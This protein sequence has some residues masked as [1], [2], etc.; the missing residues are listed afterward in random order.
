MKHRCYIVAMNVLC[1]LLLSVAVLAQ[2][3]TGTVPAHS[4]PSEANR[5]LRSQDKR[6]FVQNKG[7]WNSQAQFL[8][9]LNN[10]RAWITNNGIVYDYYT[11]DCPT[12]SEP[13]RDKET[14]QQRIERLHNTNIKGHVVSMNFVSSSASTYVHGD[15]Q[16]AAQFNY[17]LGSDASKWASNVPLYG[18]VVQNNV[19]DGIDVR[20]YYD[21]NNIR[22]DFHV[23]AGANPKNI[24]LSFSGQNKLELGNDG[25]LLIGTTMG[26]I[27]HH[28]LFAYQII[29]GVKKQVSCAFV[30]RQDG[31]VV[32]ELGDYDK[33]LELIIDPLIYSTYL[34]GTNGADTAEGLAVDG[35][36]NAYVVSFT[37][38]TN[39]PMTVGNYDNTA[40]GLSDVVVSKFSATGSLTYSTY[41]GGNNFDFARAI[42]VDGNGNAFVTGSTMSPNYPVTAGCYDNSFNAGFG[43]GADAF[44]TKLNSSGNALS[45]ST[46]LGG[47]G[48]EEG[49]GIVVNAN[50]EAYVGG[51]ELKF[52]AGRHPITAGAYNVGVDNTDG[53]E[54]I[55]VTKFNNAGTG[56]IYSAL[57]G[58]T[59]TTDSFGGISLDN[60][61]NAVVLGNTNGKN[62]PVTGGVYQSSNNGGQDLFVTKLNANGTG[63]LLSTFVGGLRNEFATG[64]IAVDGSNDIYIVGTTSLDTT[65]TLNY[66]TTA[67][68]YRTTINRPSGDNALYNDIVVTKLNSTASSLLYSTF[69]GTDSVEQ[70]HGMCIDGSGNVTVLGVTRDGN[71][72]VTATALQ[73]AP[74]GFG[75]TAA[76]EHVV[77]VL[78]TSGTALLYSTYLGG[79]GQES[80]PGGIWRDA[81]GTI[82]FA[83]NSSSTNYP[84]TPGSLAPLQ[85]GGGAD[86]VLVR[87]STVPAPIYVDKDWANQSN[88]NADLGAGVAIFGTT[89]FNT[90]TGGVN[91]AQNGDTVYVRTG[92]SPYNAENVNIN[93]SIK[94]ANHGA[95]SPSTTACTFSL[96]NN[97]VL[98]AGSG[99]VTAAT[100]N[101]NIGSKIADGL[102][103]VSPSGTV[104]LQAGTYTEQIIIDNKSNISIT[105]PALVGGNPQTTIS[106]SVSGAVVQST[107][108]GINTLQNLTITMNTASSQTFGL[109][110]SG[111]SS[112]VHLF[113]VKWIRNG[114]VI[115]G[116]NNGGLATANIPANINDGSD[117]GFGPGIFVFDNTPLGDCPSATL[118][119]N[120]I[121]CSGSPTNLT[122]TQ[123]AGVTPYSII[124]SD[125]ANNT[126]IS[127]I[128]TS[129]FTFSVSPTANTTYT[130]QSIADANCTSGNVSGSAVITILTAF[131][132]TANPSTICTPANITVALSNSQ[133]NV[134]Y[135]LRDNGNDILAA[136]NGNGQSLTWTVS[137]PTAGSHIYTVK[138]TVINNTSCTLIMNGSPTVQVNS[139]PTFTACPTNPTVNI[140]PNSC[141]NVV[142]YSTAIGVSGTPTPTISYIFSGATSGIGNGTGS[143]STFNKG[144]TNVTVRA[145]NSCTS[146]VCS[147]TV[148]VVDNQ[149]P[150]ISCPTNI[151]T[152]VTTNNCGAVVNYPLPT[153]SDNCPIGAS[154]VYTGAMQTYTVPAGVTSIRI[155]AYGAQGGTGANGAGSGVSTG[156]TGGFG[157]SAS[158][159]LSVTP[160]EVLNIFVGGQGGT[161]TAG[162][163]GGGTGGSQNAGG[164]GGATDVRQGGSA[165]VNRVIVA[166]GGGGGG[167][168]GCDVNG[169]NG[170]NGGSGDA[171]GFL[172]SNSPSGG[173]GFP[174]QGAIGGARGIGCAGFLGVNGQNAIAEVGGNGGNGQTCCCFNGNSIPGGGGGGG[175]FIGGGGGGGG[176]AGTTGCS[177]NEKGG[178]GG[179][180]GGSSYTGTLTSA[181][182]TSGVQVGNGFVMITPIPPVVTQTNGLASGATFPIGTTTNTFSITDNAGLTTTCSFTVTVQAPEINVQ[183][184]SNNIVD[185]S[186]TTSAT[187]NT[188]MGTASICGGSINKS[189][190]IQNTGNGT[191]NFISNA[192]DFV[193]ITGSDA[194]QFSVVTQP[195]A[196]I[197]AGGNANFTVAFTPTSAGVKNA[198]I[199]IATNDCDET[200]YDFAIT[201]TGSNVFTF[202]GTGN[203]SDVARWSPSYPGTSLPSACSIV[204]AGQATIPSTVTVTTGGA[205]TINNGASLS[206]ASGSS[207]LIPLAAGAFQ[208]NGTLNISG[209]FTVNKEI[210]SPGIINVNAG[211]IVKGTGAITTSTLTIPAAAFIAPGTSP[212]CLTITGNTTISGTMQ[213]E[214]AGATVCTQYDRLIVSGLATISSGST[215][216]LSNYT[217]TPGVSNSYTIITANALTGTFT[218]V[219]YPS[220]PGYC[221]TLTYT[222]SSLTFNVS[223][224]PNPSFSAFPTPVCIGGGSPDYTY[225]YTVNP[226]AVGGNFSY[227]WTIPTNATVT[228]GSATSASV[229]LRFTSGTTANLSCAVTRNDIAPGCAKTISQQ[230]QI[231]ALPQNFSPNFVPSAACRN[232]GT[233]AIQIPNSQVGVS[234]T[235][236]NASNLNTVVG[237]ATVNGNGLTVPILMNTTNTNLLTGANVI[238]IIAQN[239]LTGCE[240]R[241]NAG[242]IVINENPNPTFTAVP[243]P[244]CSGGGNPS[245]SYTYSVSPGSIGSSFSYQWLLPTNATV[246][247]GSVNSNTVTLRWAGNGANTLSCV[248]T[249]N[250]VSPA[251]ATT[252]STTVNVNQSPLGPISGSTTTCPNVP[253]TYSVPNDPNVLYTWNITPGNNFMGQ[254]T[255][256]IQVTWTSTGT[257]TISCVMENSITG[258]DNTVTLGVTVNTVPAPS[259]SG[260][261]SVCTGT[262]HNYTVTNNAGSTYQWSASGGTISGSGNSISVLW[263]QAGAQTVTVTET[264]NNGCSTSASKSVNVYL[265]PAPSISGAGT[266]CAGETKTY[267]T[268]IVSGMTNQW[269]VS[270]NGQIL[271]NNGSNID[272]KWNGVSA[273][274]T[275]TLTQIN[276]NNTSCSTTVVYTV[277]VGSVPT[278]SFTA[279]PT[280]T[281]VGQ[282]AVYSISPISGAT[283]VW[284][285]IGGTVI[286]AA[287]SNSITVQWNTVSNTNLVGVVATVGACSGGTSV[288]VIT[289]SVPN[290]V[291]TGDNAAC[292]GQTKA[293]I[294]A[295]P[296]TQ[297]TYL[298]AATN[299]ATFPNGNNSA[300]TNILFNNQGLTN[301]TVT[302]TNQNCSTTTV[303]YPVVVSITPNP[304]LSSTSGGLNTA[305]VCALSTHNYSVSFVSG[306]TYNWTVNGGTITAGAG[307]N[308]ITV[309]WGTPGQGSIALVQANGSCSTSVQTPITINPLPSPAINGTAVGCVNQTLSYSTAFT[310]GRSYSWVV[311]INGQPQSFSAGTNAATINVPWSAAGAGVVTVT[312][313]ITATG[314]SKTSNPYNVI[315]NALPTPSISGANAA[316][317]G[318]Q[319]TYSTT[320][321]V[322]SQYVWTVLPTGTNFTG[323]GSN[324]ITV[325][326][327]SNNGSVQV[328]ETNAA[329][330]TATS[331]AVNVT[332]NALPAP[333]FTLAQVAC[334]NQQ[335][336]L[337]VTTPNGTS[338]YAWTVPGASIISGST[339]ST[340]LTVL[341]NSAGS[342]TIGLSETTSAGCSASITKSILINTLPIPV[343]NGA[344]SACAGDIK[345]YNVA[346]P[347]TSSTYSWA[348][349]NGS[350]QGA[351]TGTSISVLWATAGASTVTVTETTT[352]G[353]IGSSQPYAVT[354]NAKPTPVISSSTSGLATGGVCLNSIHSYST[355]NN[356]SAQYLW[357]VTGG[358]IL[359][360]QNSASIQVQWTGTGGTIKVREISIAQCT[361][362]TSTTIII[363]NPPA[364]PAISGDRQACVGQSKTY[365]VAFQTG[366]SYS[367]NLTLNGNPVSFSQTTQGN[368][369][370]LTWGAAGNAV[371]NLTATLN[372]CSVNAA[373][374]QVTVNA[375][376]TPLIS[377]DASACAG[378]SK[379]YSTAFVAGNNYQWTVTPTAS[380]SGQG[381][382]S[383]IVAWNAANS[384]TVSVTET[385][386]AGCPASNSKTV[387]VNAKPQPVP[388]GPAQACTGQILN[389]TATAVLSGSQFVWSVDGTN[390][391]TSSSSPSASF[392]ITTAGQHTV[393]IT[394]TSTQGCIGF[395]EVLV[396]VALTPAPAINGSTSVC[397]GSVINY[398][399]LQPM[400]NSSFTWNVLNGTIQGSAAGS[401]ISVL[402][403]NAGSGT[404]QVTETNTGCSGTSN[405]INVTVKPLPT[406]AISSNSGGLATF[407]VCEGSTHNYSTPVVSGGSY[408]WTV[409]NGTITTGQSSNAITVQWNENV[410]SGSIKVRV[411]AQQCT[412]ETAAIPV[413]INQKPEPAFSYDVN[414]CE[415]VSKTYATTF[416]SGNQYVWTVK[417]N[418]SAFAFTNGANAATINVQWTTPGSGEVSVSETVPSTGCSANSAVAMI[419]VNP[420]PNPVV[421]PSATQLCAG[422]SATF[423][424]VNVNGHT[425][426][427]TVSPTN[428][429]VQ[430][431]G[432]NSITVTFPTAGTGTV[433]VLQTNGQTGC[434]KLSQIVNVTI[435]AV[436]NPVI[437]GPASACANSNQTFA[438]QQPGTNSSFIWSVTGG[439]IAS[440]AGTSSISVLWGGSGTGTVT[441]TEVIGICSTTVS[442]TVT[443]NPLPAPVVSGPSPVCVGSTNTY[444]VVNANNSSTFTWSFVGG[445]PL[446]GTTGSSFS[447]Q[448]AQTVQTA[449]VQ[450]NETN[451]FGC[452][453]SSSQFAVTLVAYPTPAITS[454]TGGIPKAC[455]GS[456]HSY[457]T[458]LVAG[459]SYAWTINAPT[460][461]TISINNNTVTLGYTNAGTATIS[462]KE[463]NPTGC[464]TL[465]TTQVA[466]NPLPNPQISGVQAICLNRTATFGTTNNSG[467]TYLWTATGGGVIQGANN[468]PTV[469]VLF[470]SVSPCTLLVTETT[471]NGCSKQ[472]SAF[473][474]TVNPLP[475]P[476]ISSPSGGLPAVCAL[477]THSYTTPNVSGNSYAWNVVGGTIS[478]GQGTNTI[479][480][481]W[482]NGTGG[483][484]SVTETVNATQCTTATTS[485]VVINPLPAPQVVGKTL[486]CT[487]TPIRYSVFFVAGHSYNW[488]VSPNGTIT[489][490]T[491]PSEIFVTWNTTGN[492]TVSVLQTNS[493][494]GCS[495][496]SQIGVQV[497]A[498]PAPSISGPTTVCAS[499]NANYSVSNTAGNTYTWTVSGGTIINGQGSASIQVAWGAAGSY[500]LSVVE[501][502]TQLECEGSNSLNVLVNPA[503]APVVTGLSLA[504]AGQTN[505]YTTPLVTGDSYNWTVTGGSIESGQGT[506]QIVVRWAATATLGSVMVTESNGLCSKQSSQIAVQIFQLA[507]VTMLGTD[508]ACQGT[509]SIYEVPNVTSVNYNWTVSGGTIQN[510]QGSNR[511]TVLWGNSSAGQVTVTVTSPQTSCT[512]VITRPVV[513]N[514]PPTVTIQ[515]GGN[516][517]IC[518]GESVPLGTT[519]LGF[520]SY[521]WSN[522]ATTSGIA[523][524]QPGAYSVTVTDANGCSA[525][526]N[527]IVISVATAPNPE[528][529]AN[530]PLQFCAGGSVT[531]NAGSGFI[532]Y[533]WS[534]GATTQ[535]IN[536][537]SPGL[538]TVAVTNASGCERTSPPVQVIV[539]N[540]P[541]PSISAN[542][543]LKFCQGNSVVLDAGS[544]YQ[545]YL[546]STGATTRTI[547]VTQ[548]GSYSVQAFISASCGGTSDPVVVQVSAVPD[549]L[550][551][552]QGPTTFCQ[553]ESVTLKANDGMASYAWSTG[554]TT[555]SITVTLSG[556]YTV[557]V[558]NSSGCIDASP[559]VAV[560]VNPLPTPV[561]T[562]TGGTLTVTVANGSSYQWQLSQQ[563]VTGATQQSFTPTVSGMYRV[564]VTNTTGCSAF[565]NEVE[566]KVGTSSVANE[567]EQVGLNLRPNPVVNTVTVNFSC[568][569]NEPVR[570][571]IMN[572]IGVQVAMIDGGFA[573]GTYERNIDLSQLASGTY[574]MRIQVGNDVFMKRFVVQK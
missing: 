114:I 164:G 411:I 463:T 446:N 67:G 314:C 436:P 260:V 106:P 378:Q 186:T 97:A 178:G 558:S 246:V 522:G 276:Q 270:T 489:A 43:V 202:T 499:S 259:I 280:P 208:N 562:L 107:G 327:G 561:V 318:E 566:V 472:S 331:A 533:R 231:Q 504:C 569:C 543:P 195:P 326:W 133:E 527:T 218:N 303:A 223:Q 452:S 557:T 197:A 66:P 19:Y 529:T 381:T 497:V 467:S 217:A 229:T 59:D 46:F 330:C 251:C 188:D 525:T 552:P 234:Y 175:G 493:A 296:S 537:T 426:Q 57:W 34:G 71:Y 456:T 33:T 20:Y 120:A 254:G 392:S 293:Y 495:N 386:G 565:S 518:E 140:L 267:S 145:V 187:N 300:G 466:V 182:V 253:R 121:I 422:R 36:G 431:Q 464:S 319:K 428:A 144:V 551:S 240:R 352:N 40:N 159:I 335:I 37:F 534:N 181:S 363:I 458:P 23:Q 54:S 353:C 129:P 459:N 122:V 279:A 535:S 407:G 215:L 336:N 372:G 542:G 410:S 448:W 70:A 492:K 559:A 465:V 8:A 425:F 232:A 515:A 509:T 82:T 332:V 41:I 158:G 526:S 230:V 338:T 444:Q 358:N 373:S 286:G 148:T 435:G 219:I 252:I 278:P 473:V 379:T 574:V 56:L 376:P 200:N 514:V 390:V 313:T 27:K 14:L 101:V 69:L 510:G 268:P 273:S 546:W 356:A 539:T 35:S 487:N 325:T 315:V 346:S 395:A 227:A 366:V 277:N 362:E 364:T 126:T 154:F 424:V 384:Y 508:K 236:V 100:I 415:G 61:G 345:T 194:S 295:Q 370:T 287:T 39:Y 320:S 24:A 137:N 519:T 124:Y 269:S 312:E 417:L 297:T 44:V 536:V 155:D 165:T 350:I 26:E 16:Q 191:L 324:S 359:S 355:S 45:Y 4:S 115:N 437:T 80:G 560:V 421:S 323:Q 556:S 183:G 455:V 409:T 550:V 548:A 51:T 193:T 7:Q 125:G 513:L 245:Y 163:N 486:A 42:T 109:V 322:G 185:G 130:L 348:V 447:I 157:S 503:P 93:K 224:Q 81:A 405:T 441:V 498:A 68:A 94:F 420:L 506:N 12:S 299:G 412:T 213:T 490:G 290:P 524:T 302:E 102:L 528:I 432:T 427:W 123:T 50:G 402:W 108:S 369:V 132:V 294:V 491:A 482:S 494:T 500:S 337:A 85:P 453:G 343:V 340:A 5:M 53:F 62:Y 483:T 342:K 221:M 488:T 387:V 99:G 22:Y 476:V 475:A 104:N 285:T 512:A 367:W 517:S 347:S 103:L 74:A 532:R 563:N 75:G 414:V 244:V 28:K 477:S 10:A 283:Y 179:G 272:V 77:T 282:Q 184:N 64:G 128:N 389:F 96:T 95:G 461:T 442:K 333:N 419:N 256:S 554:E 198:V 84:T 209:V 243:T 214:I 449:F 572:L 9:R 564:R 72:P 305:G 127:N 321:N 63:L 171:N 298:W 30:I 511:L 403:A 176:S 206:L 201:A 385:T 2:K 361:T 216:D 55:F 457:T 394:E 469:S 48:N 365:T 90:I 136:Q 334:V 166:A 263:S 418:G 567:G 173:G 60:A 169:V 266:A 58:T 172:G 83:M 549:A 523:V 275:V 507:G 1:C 478:S 38:S 161:P 521:R 151:T 520:S 265:T 357:T 239:I 400:P 89:A 6:F 377:G 388:N 76:F 98:L 468:Q 3:S 368:S 189:F 233:I 152:T 471:S 271:A 485:T 316:C 553:G 530:G 13:L 555:Q 168:G 360:G 460:G 49:K 32:L 391:T 438:L 87:F 307:S 134:S 258:C 111:N 162:F 462:V 47:D 92:A 454:A 351:T 196:T 257:K 143:G 112:S 131:N 430:G 139:P 15:R 301:I 450:V 31:N 170:G 88:V 261:A 406:A 383:I 174:G 180:A 541:K 505:T 531:L 235:A 341:W 264:N 474:V 242:T 502:N 29:N 25:E 274:S 146:A 21:G 344:N 78:N 516:T 429:T 433:Q 138:A 571:E 160:G 153:A 398:A 238:T 404:V 570:I 439:S 547:T 119:G 241:V 496:S 349:S 310:S 399:V 204:I 311:T 538:Y 339:S 249:R 380:F 374:Y 306:N 91:A 141:S 540:A 292:V 247:S 192:P 423:S 237:T 544:G 17:F 573:S 117:G 150:S 289:R 211:G 484:V 18:E 205:F 479:N 262:S 113:N 304:V 443:I 190:T 284:N 291:I 568:E 210:S 177:F 328:T 212:G 317:A 397:A 501:R 149:P 142:N 250:D 167:R 79:N 434:S 65:N 396:Q 207:F 11:V 401:S 545:T 375:L 86:A 329:N 228:A 135:Q 222:A 73:S 281:C 416:V 480:V 309:V 408:L 382:N 255:S 451:S 354:V 199:V 226:G 445:T 393:R 156:G 220:L 413:I 248:V 308:A 118:S 440:G 481:V 225:T 203:W 110:P 105:G 470:N 52:G 288:N 147:F 116:T 371:V